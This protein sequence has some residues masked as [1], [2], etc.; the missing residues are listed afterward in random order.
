MRFVSTLLVLTTLLTVGASKEA[1]IDPVTR[2]MERLLPN[3]A[4]S[5]L[6]EF[7]G[8]HR[9]GGCAEGA[10]CFSIQNGDKPGTISIAGS[11]GVEQAAGLH[12]YLRRFCGAHLGWEAT[13]GHQL[14]SVPRGSLPPVDDAGVVVNLPFERTV[15]MNPETFS[16][17]TAFWDYERWEKEIEWMALHGVNTPMALNGVEQVWMHVLTSEDFGLKES[18]VEE[19]FGDPAHQAWARNGAAQGSW[20]GG[21]PKKWLK[22]QWDLQRDAVKL[23]RDFG[24]TPVLPGFNG[25]VPPAIARRFPEAKLRRVENWLTGETTVERDHR[26]RERPATTEEGGKAHTARDGDDS[27]ARLVE[28]DSKWSEHEVHHASHHHEEKKEEEKEEKEERT[29]VHHAS[30]HHDEKK[31]EEKEEE[32]HH[33][34]LALRESSAKKKKA[35][36]ELG[37]AKKDDSVRSVHFLD[38]SD[39]LFQSLGAAFTKQL[40]EDFGTD[41]LYLADTFREIRDPNDDFS[42]SHVARVGAATLAAMRSADP[43]ATWVFQSDA[44]HRNPRFW[45]EGRRGALLRSVDIGDMLVLDSAAETDPYYLREPMHFAGQP[46]VWCVKHNHGGNLGMRGRL[47]AIATGPAAAMDSLAS[48]TTHGRGTRVGSSRRMLAD[49]KRVSGE[50]TRGSRKVGKSQLAGFGITAEGVEQNPVVY[51]LAALTSQ[52]EKG[53]DVDWFLADYSRR[54]YGGYSVR[55]PAP[56][57]LPVG[58]GQGAF[59]AGFIVGNNPIAGSPGYLGPGEWYDPAKHGEMGKEEAYDRAREAWEILGKTV[60]GARAKG[61]DED[62]VRDACSW[63]PSLRA[64]ELSPDYFDAAKVVEYAFKPL[65]DA[66]PTLRANGAGTRVDY[67]LV[68]VGRQLLARQSNVL[69]TQ[70]RD[71]L[72][73]NNASEAKMYGTQMLELLD[74]MDALLRSHK[75]FLLGNYIESAK[76]WAGKRDKESDEANLERSARSLISGFGPS[77]SKLGAPLGHPMHDYS[78]RQWSGMLG[79]VGEGDQGLYYRRW[80]A[81]LRRVVTTI[82][83]AEEKEKKNA[84]VAKIGEEEELL[85]KKELVRELSCAP[86]DTGKMHCTTP[87]AF[88]AETKHQSSHHKDHSSSHHSHRKHSSGSEGTPGESEEANPRDG[89]STAAEMIEMIEAEDAKRPSPIPHA[90]HPDWD[91]DAWEREDAD[92]VGAWVEETGKAFT[93]EPQ[94]DPLQVAKNVYWK[95]KEAIKSSPILGEPEYIREDEEAKAKAAMWLAQSEKSETEEVEMVHRK[96]NKRVTAKEMISR[97]EKTERRRHEGYL[98]AEQELLMEEKSDVSGSDVMRA[99][100]SIDS[101]VWVVVSGVCAT[102]FIACVASHRASKLDARPYERYDSYPHDERRPLLG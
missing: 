29:E 86:D 96:K 80:S 94:G 8:R 70:I 25:H 50:A 47:S 23:M 81:F 73:S 14:H 43:R 101:T 67:D 2:L 39:A 59:L 99:M 11:T 56:T 57:T 84:K 41:H 65:I 4:G 22:R 90:V 45:N 21:R 7:R 64:D 26:E 19:W 27:L 62:H 53:V 5:N 71:S 87:G 1:A 44:F 77:G 3:H 16:Y 55:Q 100:R 68:D 13:G 89:K 74:D 31:E 24:M 33:A 75:G 58:T 92:I 32:S 10:R 34:D 28:L 88:S 9:D 97:L 102:V 76:S 54:R 12:H 18:E 93:T 48:G 35:E 60:Y 91:Q 51:E 49:N 30:H 40:V 69:A 17:S 95:Y 20:T 42:E 38:P 72:N 85:K 15:Y 79:R 37:E 78:N 6:I 61:K 46:F 52:S 63:Q 82:E 66:A 98:D 83:K 36:A